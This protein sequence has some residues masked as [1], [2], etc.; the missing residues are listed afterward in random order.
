MALAL[1]CPQ[2]TSRNVMLAVLIQ[3]CFS[4]SVLL[5]PVS[6]KF[7]RVRSH[8]KL[9]LGILSILGKSCL[10]SFPNWN[11]EIGNCFLIPGVCACKYLWEN[12][13]FNKKL[14][15]FSDLKLFLTFFFFN[16]IIKYLN[17][18]YL[19]NLGSPSCQFGFARGKLSHS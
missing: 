12:K 3:K 9:G 2:E 8:L 18:F 10:F 16:G 19:R 5:T 4:R 17:M 15:I 1:L 11:H 7:P 6:F 13:S 14:T